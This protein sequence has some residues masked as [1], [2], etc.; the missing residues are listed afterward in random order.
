MYKFPKPLY[1]QKSK[2]YS[3][4]ILLSFRPIWHFGPAVAH[5]FFSFQ[6]AAPPLPT[7]PWPLNRPSRP[8]CR[9]RPTG[10]PPPP[11]EDASSHATFAL[12]SHPTDRWTPPVIPHLWPARARSRRHHL[13]SLPAPPSPTSNVTRAFTTPQLFPLP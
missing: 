10:L 4:I 2:F 7:G 9:W 6:P 13:P 8:A 11:Q 5:S 12:S 3:E 1:I